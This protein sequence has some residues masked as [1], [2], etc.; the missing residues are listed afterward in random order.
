MAYSHIFFDLDGTLTDSA[1]GITNAIIYARKK[2]GLPAGTNADYYKFIGPPMPESYEQ[3]WGFSHEDAVRFLA[4]YREYFSQKGLFENNVYPG[5]LSLLQDLKAAGR[6]LYIA[7]TKPTEFSQR[8]ADKFGF[9]QYFDIISGAGLTSDNTKY[10]VIRNA[11]DA[12]GVDMAD[13]VMVGDRFHDVEGAHAHHIP[14]I[15][16]TYGFGSRE[17]LTQSGADFIVDTVDELGALL[18]A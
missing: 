6:H 8:I 4:D 5:I 12:C 13:A 11:R 18:L 7:T 3:F 1:P 14:C 16:V 17:E 15:G 10:D 2:W 9:S